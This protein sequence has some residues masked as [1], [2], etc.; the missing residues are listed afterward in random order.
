[1]SDAIRGRILGITIIIIILILIRYFYIDFRIAL[2]SKGGI[3]GTYSTEQS[4]DYG[5]FIKK[6]T[7]FP[8]E[9]SYNDNYNIYFEEA[10]LENIYVLKNN[11]LW[12]SIQPIPSS[13]FLNVKY[14]FR[15]KRT[16]KITPSS[17]SDITL[18]SIKGRYTANKGD[19]LLFIEV[20]NLEK[21]YRFN[22]ENYDDYK[23]YGKVIFK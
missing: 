10:W 22:I 21:T 11:L 2:S 6:L 15:D 18:H 9:I 13:Y 17:N 19:N 4:R 7:P 8:K 23:V 12:S 1:M 16:N 20:G 14:Y 5:V 3:V